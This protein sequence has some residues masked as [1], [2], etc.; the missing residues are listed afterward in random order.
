MILGD[1]ALS[2]FSVSEQLNKQICRWDTKKKKVFVGVCFLPCDMT[3][4][5]RW[6]PTLWESPDSNGAHGPTHIASMLVCV[7]FMTT[8]NPQR[9]LKW[10]SLWGT[11][12]ITQ[13]FCFLACSCSVPAS[14]S[15]PIPGS[16]WGKSSLPFLLFS[17]WDTF[18][19]VWA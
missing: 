5:W 16:D 12:F 4:F 9:P 15:P 1:E 6:R 19:Y 7:L 11:S 18:Q 17:V 8:F 3:L 2:C 13:S 10:G 14:C